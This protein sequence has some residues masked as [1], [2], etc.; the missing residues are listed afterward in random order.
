MSHLAWPHTRLIPAFYAVLLL[1]VMAGYS[2]VARAENITAADSLRA[3]LAMSASLDI[4]RQSFVAARQAIASA[5]A[6]N[7]LTGTL[8]LSGSDVQTDERST[9]GGFT[10]AQSALGSVTLKKQIYDFGEAESR[11][12]AAGY[13]LDAARAS[14]SRAEQQVVMDILAAHLNVITAAKTLAIRQA[15]IKRL[16]A[17]TKAEQIKLDAGSST[18]TRLA[19]AEARLA[20]ARSDEIKAQ[21]DLISEQEVYTSLTGLAGNALQDVLLPENFL[22]QN[23]SDAEQRAGTANPS[24]LSALASEQQAGLEFEIL[25]RSLLPKVNFS[26]SAAHTDK[27]GT[28]MDKDEI[29]SKIEM[30]TPFLVTEGS[31]AASRKAG[32]NMKKAKLQTSE[33]RRLARLQARK[34]F[35]DYQAA[36][37]QRTAVEAELSAAQLVAA[38]TKNEVEYGLKTFLDQ[39]DSE[40]AL[41]DTELRLVQT[42]QSIIMNGFALLQAVGQLR[43]ELF[44]AEPALPDL[45]SISDPPSRYPSMIPWPF[46][47]DSTQ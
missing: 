2:G 8:S 16:E 22:P 19:E 20:K 1:A 26:I 40:Q 32:A 36:S 34:A 9:A 11:T 25:K 13:G 21:S 15:N 29:T 14:Y 37:A 17:Q 24:V 44:T 5:N 41:S 31:R 46:G 3:G 38:G 10:S 30:S 35:R 47:R 42:R 23:I 33:A 39:L 7:D 45:D 28:A 43:A 6:K 18:P 12:K 4:E 27:A